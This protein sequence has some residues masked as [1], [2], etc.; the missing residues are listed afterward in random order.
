[1]DGPGTGVS[2]SIPA[3]LSDGEFVF[4]KK[5]TDQIGAD[6]LQVMMDDA[7][8]AFDGGY[9]MKAVGGMMEDEDPE[10]LG[11]SKTQEEIEKL[12]MGANRMP[13]LQ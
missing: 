2:D 11:M 4:T 9:Q 12:M 13:S 3:R 10:N 1:M 5:A 7:E 8:R 6:N